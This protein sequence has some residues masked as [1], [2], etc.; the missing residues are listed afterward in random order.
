MSLSHPSC[1]FLVYAIGTHLFFSVF[2]IINL[3]EKKHSDE[4][5]ANEPHV[6]SA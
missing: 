6:G 4:L 2:I 3:E 5:Q 1:M